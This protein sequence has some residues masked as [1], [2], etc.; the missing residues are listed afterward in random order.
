MP[1]TKWDGAKEPTINHFY[2]IENF[3]YGLKSVDRPKPSTV[4]HINRS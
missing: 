3:E 1:N 2:S 4:F